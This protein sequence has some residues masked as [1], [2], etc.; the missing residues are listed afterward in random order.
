MRN[1]ELAAVGVAAL[2][3]E[4]KYFCAGNLLPLAQKIGAESPTLRN[5]KGSAH[6]FTFCRD[7]NTLVA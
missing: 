5:A 3:I 4:R 7:G 2:G 1:E 6:V